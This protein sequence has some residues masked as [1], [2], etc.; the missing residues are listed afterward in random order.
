MIVPFLDIKAQNVPLRAEID[1]A[2]GRSSTAV[3]LQGGRSSRNSRKTLRPS[4]VAGTPS[5]WTAGRKRSG[6]S[7]WRWASVRETK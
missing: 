6:S 5:A 1:T 2:S 4:A 3:P 7:C